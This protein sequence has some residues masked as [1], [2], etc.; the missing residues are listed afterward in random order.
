MRHIL[1]IGGTDS[2][3]GA[4]LTRDTGVAQALGCLGKPVVTC[5]TVQTQ[6]AVKQIHQIPAP[7]IAAQIDAA[8][9]DTLPSAVKIGMVGTPLAADAI[10]RALATRDIPIVLDPVLQASS[11]G[12]LGDTTALNRLIA[13]ATLV[14]PNLDE[15]AALTRQPL[16]ASEA[17]IAAQAAR[18]H[19][20]GARAVLIKGGHGQGAQSCDHLFEG[21]T[22]HRF[23]LPRLAR[24]TR[25]TGCALAT[26]IACELAAGRDLAGACRRAKS[27]LHR[28]IAGVRPDPVISELSSEASN[29]AP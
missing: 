19:H 25:G 6:T 23:C 14:T 18:L 9:A 11:G 7:L 10:A 27:D 29:T 2:S 16:A 22:H 12:R 4:G 24:N 28:W 3:G 17:A 5:V 20:H 1:L 8:F 15:A 21:Q 26:A 13:M